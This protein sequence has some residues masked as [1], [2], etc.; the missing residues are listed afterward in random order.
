MTTET[1]GLR[2]RK[3][4]ETRERIERAALDLALANGLESVTIDAISAAA[5]ISP[6]TFFNYYDSKED[7][8]VGLHGV[9]LSPERITAFRASNAHRPLVE[10]TVALLFEVW[11]VAMD[12]SELRAARVALVRKNPQLLER[13]L[14]R[15][16]A[17][18]EQL[19]TALRAFAGEE[20]VPQNSATG[21][22]SPWVEATLALCGAAV[23]STVKSWVA[24]G[25][26]SSGSTEVLE[27]RAVALVREVIERLQ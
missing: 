19:T 8:I 6:R 16:R 14:T 23:M 1:L 21:P 3:R 26:E 4:R 9:E 25:N 18:S 2:D 22:A 11:G 27:S 20:D 24:A 12:D 15:M 5:E 7:A 10:A 13:H 17:M